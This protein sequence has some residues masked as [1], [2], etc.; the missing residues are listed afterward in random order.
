MRRK[1][2]GDAHPREVI[3]IP[4]SRADRVRNQRQRRH[5]WK[6]YSLHAPEIECIGKGKA[7][8]PYEFGVR[9]SIATANG[10][11]PGGQFMVHAKAT[12][13]THTMATPSAP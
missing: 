8:R 11:S 5:G 1:T 12:H 9:A 4:L 13:G 6:M 10:R 7:R 3:A 2:K